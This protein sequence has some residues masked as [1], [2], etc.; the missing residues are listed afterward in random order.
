[1][2]SVRGKVQLIFKLMYSFIV[3]EQNYNYLITWGLYF[4]F[5]KDGI[6]SV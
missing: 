3:A 2:Q 1:M 5:I 4:P 6:C